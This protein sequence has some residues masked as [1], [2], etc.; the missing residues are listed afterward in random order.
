M[1]L[2]SQYPN[3][4]GH[5]YSWSDLSV[6]LPG[7]QGNPLQGC[8]GVSYSDSVERE[9]V[10]GA[11]RMHRGKSA[12]VYKIEMVKLKTTMD[13]WKNNIA[14]VIA[15][16]AQQQGIGFCDVTF[17]ITVS[18]D[19]GQGVVIT[20]VI[21]GCNIAKVPNEHEQGAGGLMVEVEIDPSYIKH[22]LPGGGFYTL[23]PIVNGVPTPGSSPAFGAGAF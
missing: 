2:E 18:Y 22:G 19:R 4:N 14:P 5:E 15:S 16:V 8:N 23:V 17:P 3:V 21:E 10:P 7:I 9:K 12:G 11:G 6:A 1:G 13:D 20:D